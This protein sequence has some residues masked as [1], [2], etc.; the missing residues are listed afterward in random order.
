MN[1]PGGGVATNKPPT[2]AL[3]VLPMS[4]ALITTNRQTTTIVYSTFTLLNIPHSLLNLPGTINYGSGIHACV[5]AEGAAAAVATTHADLGSA[6]KR[7][8]RSRLS[9]SQI[10]PSA[11]PV[12]QTG[13]YLHTGH[14][15]HIHY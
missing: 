10:T 1:L 6:C 8:T 11:A 3:V 4:R 12:A 13:R 14:V 5:D 7:R 15:T 9:T 2:R